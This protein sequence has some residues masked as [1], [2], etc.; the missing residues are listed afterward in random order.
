MRKSP[1][2]ANLCLAATV[3]CL[4]LAACKPAQEAA[5]PASDAAAASAGTDAAAAPPAATPATAGHSV[6]GDVIASTN[7]P[8]WS[9]NV[10]GPVLAL[11]GIDSQR[12]LAVSSS[13]TVGDTRTLVATDA[14]GKVELKV[15][16][17][18]CQDSMSG[19]MFPFD[20]VLVID[21]GAPVSG[22]A[23]PASMPPPG[24]G[25]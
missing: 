12:S 7:E 20:A 10:S 17:K 18:Q 16:A 24:E 22:C 3:L 14:S 13:E 5:A 25:L 2:S 4:A 21:G 19:A 6:D 1:S 9:A 23:R 15:T 11:S 8:F